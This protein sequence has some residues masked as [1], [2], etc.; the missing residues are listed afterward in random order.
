MEE[1]FYRLFVR[2]SVVAVI[3][4]RTPFDY[5]KNITFITKLNQ[6]AGPASLAE[7]LSVIAFV[8]GLTIFP[9]LWSFGLFEFAQLLLPESIRFFGLLLAGCGLALFCSTHLF[10]GRNFSGT[11]EIR[12]Q[13]Q[14]VQTGLYRFVRHPMYGAFI[15]MGFSY[16]LI[17]GNAFV[18]LASILGPYLLY[19]SRV[20][21]E[22]QA[23]LA[24]FG[25]AYVSYSEKTG[26]LLPKL[27]RMR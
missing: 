20:E 16:L 27:N 19:R 24:E 14:L 12:E 22:E 21:R 23:L 7:A 9:M 8:L 13:H 3:L 4:I 25:E 10:L 11:V 6:T 18:G 15:V 5:R 17:A 1:D 2:V 26:S